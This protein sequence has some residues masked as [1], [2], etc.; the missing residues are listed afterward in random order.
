MIDDYEYSWK[1]AA[2][3]D[4]RLLKE[5]SELFSEQYGRWGKRG[6]RPGEPIRLGVNRLRAFLPEGSWAILARHRGALIGHAFG[7][8]VQIPDRGV[9]T[10]VTQLVVHAD[11]RHR[12]VAKDL[13]LTFCGFSNHFGWGLVTSN[14]FAVR[15]LERITH[16]RC[17]PEVIREHLDVLARVG[18]RIAYV[19]ERPTKVGDGQSIIDTE[20]RIDL[21]NLPGKLAK[22]RTAAPWLLGEITE[23]EEWLAFT[24]L[25]QP[26][27]NLDRGELRRMLDH[28]D[29]T[30]KQAYARMSLGPMHGWMRETA[31]EIEV[32]VRELGLT[33]GARVLDLGCGP[34]RHTLELAERG[35]EVTGVDFVDGFLEQGRQEAAQRDIRAARFVHADGRTLDLGE[36]SFD[37]A[38]C[39]YDVIGTFPE[40]AENQRLL[41]NLARHLRP[42]GR[43]LV[44]VLNMELT[45]AIA[46]RRGAVEDNPRLL[47]EL[48]PSC[49]MRET[50]NIFKPDLFLL[51]E[52]EGIVYRKEQF[53]GD[54]R[55][56]GEYIVRDRR[57]TQADLRSMCEEAG[58]R[59]L[60]MRPAALGRW[61]EEIGA[62]DP[63]AKEIVV[64]AERG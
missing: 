34:G 58:L 54:G 42:G 49:V 50:G 56:P 22:A 33:P 35:F 28:S 17:D 5:C 11:H 59:V 44:S 46:T 24:F 10:W 8:R 30:V 29:R 37:A 51:D 61:A 41:S 21:S 14:P 13:L 2:D 16:R 39:L 48:P 9:V 26:M 18:E 23:G 15:A 45:A 19:H 31:H 1:S 12:G 3:M 53:D 40:Q 62:S 47:Q 6:P 57:Y 25:D 32:A 7:V 55:P 43:A 20:F 64:L 52:Q 38:V 27:M 63:R 36:G 4:E 60:W